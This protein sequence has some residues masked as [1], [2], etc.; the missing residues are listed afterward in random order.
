VDFTSTPK[1]NLTYCVYLVFILVGIAQC[2]PSSASAG[3]DREKKVLDMSGAP[4]LSKSE[5]T[6]RSVNLSFFVPAF[7]LFAL[8]S[9]FM[10]QMFP[11]LTTTTTSKQMTSRRRRSRSSGQQQQFAPAPQQQQQQEEQA[12]WIEKF[13][14]NGLL[15]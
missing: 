8:A 14:S 15:Y 11:A 1:M 7:S 12:S 5:G 9:Q 13:I 6:P 3:D 4:L 2:L 10:P